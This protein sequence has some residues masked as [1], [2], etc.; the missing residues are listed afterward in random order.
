MFWNICQ[1][2]S[3]PTVTYGEEAINSCSRISLSRSLFLLREKNPS[4]LPCQKIKCKDSPVL[5][6]LTNS[7]GTDT[8][9]S[10]QK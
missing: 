6:N 8:R 2:K 10:F 4:W 9:D 7:L 3:V 5:E 1:V